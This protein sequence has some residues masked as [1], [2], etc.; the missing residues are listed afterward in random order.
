MNEGISYHI[1]TLQSY[2]LF[3][4]SQRVGSTGVGE[5]GISCIYF[6]VTV[7]LTIL[8]EHHYHI[9]NTISIIQSASFM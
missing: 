3:L 7:T 9:H 2:K 8:A 4:K 5:K 1:V 6:W